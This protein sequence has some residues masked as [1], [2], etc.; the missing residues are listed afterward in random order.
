MR[1]GQNNHEHIF[2][3]SCKFVVYPEYL[4]VFKRKWEMCISC[5]S[6]KYL[7]D[8]FQVYN[9]SFCLYL[10]FT[11]QSLLLCLWSVKRLHPFS[12]PLLPH[13]LPHL[14]LLSSLLLPPPPLSLFQFSL[15]IHLS[16]P[17]F[18]GKIYINQ[19]FNSNKWNN[20]KG[21]SYILNYFYFIIYGIIFILFSDI[22]N[23]W[24][25]QVRDS[26]EK[27]KKNFISCII[28]ILLW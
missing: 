5:I 10:K 8:L 11:S 24:K 18:S 26:P 16:L 2:L 28:Q 15:P 21:V 27:K 1:I 19:H 7:H 22:F 6:S 12:L 4:V 23:D 9:K 3:C 17:L 20:Q 14:S 25:W 13:L